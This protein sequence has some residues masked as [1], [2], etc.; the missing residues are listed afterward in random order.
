MLRSLRWRRHQKSSLHG[1][2]FCGNLSM[3]NPVRTIRECKRSYLIKNIP[4]HVSLKNL[5]NELREFESF[6]DLCITD[7]P[8]WERSERHRRCQRLVLC[9][10]GWPPIHRKNALIP[11]RW[12]ITKNSR[13]AALSSC[14]KHLWYLTEEL[15][16]LAIFDWGTKDSTL[17]VSAKPK[18]P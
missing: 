3:K 8:S 9:T 10:Y 11:G 12:W 1:I 5:F 6:K 14:K 7:P 15:V 18:I 2:N 4:W 17:F 16:I 13:D